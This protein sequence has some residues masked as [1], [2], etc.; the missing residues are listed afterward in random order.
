MQYLVLII[1][2]MAS[3]FG[4]KDESLRKETYKNICAREGLK[5][6]DNDEFGTI[7]LLK[8]FQLFKY[9]AGKIRNLC[10]IKSGSLDQEVNLFDYRY[11]ISTGKATA[12]FDQT[13]FFINSKSLGLPIFRMT[14]EY[15]G[16][17][18][19]AYLGWDDIDFEQYPVFSDKYYLKGDDEDFIRSAFDDNILKFF[20]KTSG[21]TIEA[22]NYYL[23]FYSKNKLVPENTLAEF[24]KL[25]M[26]IYDLFKEKT[27]L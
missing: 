17:K 10:Q 18:I 11:T 12:T 6:L 19:A 2:N 13:V 16:Y 27:D 21:W 26:G 20:S 3:I 22:A 7:A 23:I 8:C 15:I 24:Y 9:G 14:P 1:T 25:G 4:F 5:F